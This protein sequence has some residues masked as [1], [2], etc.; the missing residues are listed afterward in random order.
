MRTF[1]NIIGT[2]AIAL[3][4]TTSAQAHDPVAKSET[5]SPVFNKELPNIPGKRIVAA[6]VSYEPGAKSPSHTH[7]NSAFIYAF[8]LS[9]EIRS[10]VGDEAAKVYK[11]GESFFENPGSHH[12]I[13][14]NAS[15]EQPASLLA[16][17]VL[18]VDDNQLTTPDKK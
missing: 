7:A 1:P 13:S 3:M 12:R 18:D 15:N 11:T 10:Q 4:A 14:E 5:V 6:V 17:F 9:G 16:V 2:A 8:V